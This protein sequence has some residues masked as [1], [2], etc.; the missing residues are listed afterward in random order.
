MVVP[1]A[2]IGGRRCGGIVGEKLGVDELL[3]VAT[4]S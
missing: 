4:I 2:T 1:R 3:S